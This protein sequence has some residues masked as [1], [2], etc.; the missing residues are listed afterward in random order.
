MSSPQRALVTGATAGLGREFAFQLASR[1][2]ETVLV[3]R[4]AKRLSALAQEL[5]A[6]FP[7]LETET[8]SADLATDA[9]IAR[10]RERLSQPES[11]IDVLVN[12][13]GSGLAADFHASPLADEKALLTLLAWAPLALSH[14]VLPS[15]R[16]R[17]R[18]FILNVA[19]LAGALPSGSYSAAKA[20]TINL[21]RALAA[22]YRAD[23]VRVTAL[24]PGF[25]RTE[26]HDRMGVSAAGVPRIAW[27]DARVVA[28]EGLSA[29][30]RGRVVCVSDWRYRLVAPLI[31]AVPDR[32]IDRFNVLSREERPR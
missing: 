11:P 24:L 22:R 6:A 4:D 28:R 32:V 10:V 3:A 2:Y 25:V 30:G 19:S 8:L 27:A 12:N 13:A 31:R 20:H 9:G 1:G 18:G 7:H 26:F 21:S 17:G 14:A 16:A 15:M 29:L 5:A 23:G